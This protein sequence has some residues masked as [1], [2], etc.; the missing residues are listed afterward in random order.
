MDSQQMLWLVIGVV[1]AII[2][3]AVAIVWAKRSRDRRQEAA[4]RAAEDLRGEADRQQGRTVAEEERASAVRHDADA[5][6]E[7]ARQ[8]RV[9]AEERERTADSS[10][11]A[12]DAQ[13]R[14]ADR[15]DPEVRTDRE[16]RR[17]DGADSTDSA[18]PTG[19]TAPVDDA[20]PGKHAADKP[21]DGDARG[22]R[23]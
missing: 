9:E 22:P 1:V 6:E 20:G 3:I 5:A 7:Q 13:L 15:L 8:L 4:H 12:L 23:S 21:L 19:E 14:E 17:I 18:D 2:I 16:G 11:G 10:R